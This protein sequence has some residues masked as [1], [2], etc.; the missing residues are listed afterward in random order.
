MGRKLRDL[1]GA[2][3]D[4]ASQ[5]KAAFISTP[6]TITL[7]LAV[8]RVTTHSPSTPPDDHHISALLSL[9]NSSRSTA[10]SLI[11]SLIDRLHGTSNSTVALKCLLTLHHIIK[12]GP[13]ILQDQLSIFPAT[14]GRNY[15]KLS[16]FRDGATSLTWV[17]SAWV[18]WY[19]RYVEILLSNSRVLGYFLGST[20]GSVEK[21]KQE[22][23]ISSS[24]NQN[25]IKDVDSLVGMI[26]EICEV[27]DP[28]FVEGN[29]LLNEVI[30]LLGNDYLS[31]VNE[32][33]S[34]LGEFNERLGCLS[35]GESV[36]LVC[37]LKRLEDCKEKLS[38]LFKVKK[39]STETLWGLVTEL[40]EKIET[41]KVEKEE[42]KL[43]TWGKSDIKQVSQL[44]L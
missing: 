6:Q 13:F 39:P 20:T 14:G 37:V 33:L 32:L 21:D 42:R 17:L 8:L 5:S 4:K 7:R 19:A 22:E 44:G 3:K 40:E 35:F 25:L 34:R 23:R 18:R 31:T 1:I 24:L 11:S 27:P 9:G 29:K 38:L 36:E 12:R 2:V 10:S 41:L 15:L 26:E 30:S 28:S 43:L 16:A